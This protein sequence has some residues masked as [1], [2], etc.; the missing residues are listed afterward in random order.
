MSARR[1]HGNLSGL[2]ALRG[3]A[4]IA[5]LAS[6]FWPQTHFPIPPAATV[7]VAQFGVIL[8]FF[9]S[10]FLMDLTYSAEPRLFPY[11]VRRSFRILPM[12]WLS[13]VLVV[14]T[15]GGWSLRDVLSNAFFLTAPMHVDRMYGVYWTLYIEVLFYAAVPLL[16]LVGWRAILASPYIVT[17]VFGTLWLAGY[18]AAVAPH[19]LVYCCLGLCFGAWYRKVLSGRQLSAAVAAVVVAVG[20]LPLVAPFPEIVSPLQGAAPLICAVLL[21]VA[22]RFPFR[23]PLLAFFGAISYSL[24]LLHGIV[25]A[26]VVPRM[27]ARGYVDWIAWIVAIGLGIVISFGSFT[28]VETSMI[29]VGKRIIA[30]WRKVP[31][32]SGQYQMSK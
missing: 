12:Y 22:L 8:F 7:A 20:M 1:D 9:L 5:V 32:K 4:I 24:Y 19:Y 2:D 29:G 25:F 21:Y 11:A 30:R 28:F 6:H 13:L 23:L 26:E 10:G 3:I 18:R 14:A 31:R 17:V 16:F 15:V 27:L